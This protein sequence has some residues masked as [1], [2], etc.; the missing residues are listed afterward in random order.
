MV[1]SQEAKAEGNFWEQ[2]LAYSTE[3]VSGHSELVT[4]YLKKT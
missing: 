4:L 1:S 2:K 3:K